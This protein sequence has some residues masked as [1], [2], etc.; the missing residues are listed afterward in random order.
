MAKADITP[1]PGLAL[2]RQPHCDPSGRARLYE[3]QPTRI[4]PRRSSLP[5]LAAPAP[6][7]PEPTLPSTARPPS[8]AHLI[9]GLRQR[10]QAIERRLS[11][12]EGDASGPVRSR[13]M[14]GAWVLGAPHI[15]D[16]LGATGLDPAA[17]H[18]IKP[19]SGRAS[20]SAAALAFTLALAR[21]RLE[22]HAAHG[23][24]TSKTLP[25]ILW[26]T[27]R[28][29]N[30]DLGMLHAAGLARFG[31]DAS[32]FLMLEVQRR[33]D[34]LWALEEGLRSES[35][36]MVIGALDKVDLTPARRLSLAARDGRTP[37]ILL[38]PARS[39]AT[40][41]T[42]TRWRIAPAPSAA[43]PFDTRTPGMPRLAVNLERCRSAPP[44][45]ETA[46]TLEWSDETH[47]FRMASPLADRAAD[48]AQARHRT[49]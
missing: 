36:A 35:L 17:C 16:L 19:G 18:E 12:D 30:A 40:G 38:T 32:A 44:A 5:P 10:V 29:T 9:E 39:P 27:A 48:A 6:L 21:R 2:P 22:T 4:C 43:H 11:L 25:R 26:C 47:R 46:L 41:A 1:D 24:A 14:A 37:L 20:A 15:D 34:V 31:L 33:K 7:L 8:R 28:G 23:A 49:G 45:T 42:A 13:R 3:F